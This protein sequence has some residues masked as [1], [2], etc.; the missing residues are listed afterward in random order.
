[1]SDTEEINEVTLKMPT[2]S[3]SSTSGWFQIL[4]ANFA[5][6]KITKESTKFLHLL[7]MLTPEVITQL[8]P[9]LLQYQNYTDIK[10]TILKWYEK[11]KP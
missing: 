10:Q 6:K 8:P 2:F 4:E 5:L 3:K 11:T 7:S 9:N 1:M